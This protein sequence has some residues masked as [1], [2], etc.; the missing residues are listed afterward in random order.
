M[1]SA[2]A[3]SIEP[4]MPGRTKLGI[5]EFSYNIRSRAERAGYTPTVT[6]DPLTFLK[7]CHSIGAGGLQYV[8]G[9]RDEAYAKELRAYVEDNDL[10]IEEAVWLGGKVDMDGF[11]AGVRSA[12]AV[13]AR[14]IRAFCGNR[15]YEQFN[16]REQFDEFAKR[17]WNN[18]ESVAPDRREVPNPPGD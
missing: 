12:K 6:H 1:L 13:G 16:K 9:T 10:F 4:E 17:S 3:W 8:I 11:E 18:I 15:R 5:D 14:A 2:P 7:Y